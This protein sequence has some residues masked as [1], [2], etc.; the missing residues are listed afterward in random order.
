MFPKDRFRD[1]ISCARIFSFIR[2]IF[3]SKQPLK[4]EHIILLH[5]FDLKWSA[6]LFSDEQSGNSQNFLGKLVRFF[7]TLGI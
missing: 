7:V 5:K 6:A 1:Q 4:T 3:I 2:L